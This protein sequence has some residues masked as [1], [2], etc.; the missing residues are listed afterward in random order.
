MRDRER[1]QTKASSIPTNAFNQAET[2]LFRKRPFAVFAETETD[3]DAHPLPDLQTQLE[4][5]ARFNESLSRMKVY[6]NRPVIQP[7]I[8]IG[9]PGDRYE[10]EADRMA[11]Q[12]MSMPAAITHPP[13]QRW[14]MPEEAQESVQTKPLADSITPLVQRETAPAE[15]EENLE[16]DKEPLQMKRSL[17]RA[18]SSD[19]NLQTSSNLESQLSSNKGGGSPLSDEVR[20]FMEPRFGADF[21]QVQVHTDSEAVQM[22]RELSAQ[23]F[24]HGSDVYFGAGKYNPS[25]SDGKQ[26]LAHELTHVVQQGGASELKRKPV[27]SVAQ[28]DDRVIQRQ[29]KPT[30]TPTADQ[31]IRLTWGKRGYGETHH[32][33]PQSNKGWGRQPD[34]RI[35]QRQPASQ[36]I[37][38]GLIQRQ[39]ATNAKEDT[40]EVKQAKEDHA[41]FVASSYKWPNYTTGKNGKF[42]VDY[43]PSSNLVDITVKVKFEFPDIK[44]TGLAKLIREVG[45]RANYLTQVQNAWSN[46]Y[47]FKNVR[48]PQSIWGKLNPTTVNVNVVPVTA[49]EHFLIQAYLNKTGTS[50]VSGGNTGASN[51]TKL[52]KGSDTPRVGFNNA[53]TSKGELDRIQRIN[54]SPI[55][56]DNNSATI[57][58][59]DQPKLGFLATYLKRISNPKFDIDIVGHASATGNKAN[60]QGLSEKRAQAVETALKSAGLTNH[61]LNTSGVGQTGATADAKWRK[62]D[63]TP[64]LPAGWQ[65]V[66]QTDVHEFGHMIGLG[67]EY[68]QSKGTPPQTTHYPLVLKAFGKEYADQT[69]QRGDSP[70]ASVMHFG[71]DIRI[72]HY[73]TF[74]EALCKTTL[75]KAAVPT[76]KFGYDDWK[77]IG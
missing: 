8:A 5:G 38:W 52:F 6:G 18:S 22:N 56:F 58:A 20:S 48:E 45:Y 32:T 16:Q 43:Q 35:I 23:A 77:F 67:D 66:F 11:Q 21:S 2:G 63:I 69:V 7:K 64:Q 14:E 30:V 68:W 29:T 60:N 49:N 39:D 57:N 17:Q 25:S 73:V 46:R 72:H 24:T 1:I 40:P 54:P 28:K 51:T 55:L 53:S 9:S 61:N 36:Y 19:G 47:T 33:T 75:Q 37:G 50:A 62:V 74:W 70:S 12:V 44:E 65:N 10:Q 42:D 31:G 27:E 41:K 59:G 76:K 71:N 15:L 26:L 3:T 4:R 13:I 34:E